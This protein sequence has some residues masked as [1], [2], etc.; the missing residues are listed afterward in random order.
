MG[1]NPSRQ[2]INKIKYVYHYHLSTFKD[3]DLDFDLEFSILRGNSAYQK[4][5]NVTKDGNAMLESHYLI[6]YFYF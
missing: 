1:A 3:R 4:S 6:N 5:G 2:H